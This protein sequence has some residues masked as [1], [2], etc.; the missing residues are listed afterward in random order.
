MAT[1]KAAPDLAG[2]LGVLVDAIA[3]QVIARMGG[4]PASTGK[5]PSK[6]NGESKEDSKELEKF[7][8]EARKQ[9]RDVYMREDLGAD[10]AKKI[11]EEVGAEEIGKIETVAELKK[12]TAAAKKAL[13]AK[14]PEK[15]EKASGDE[16]DFL[17]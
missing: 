6:A 2:A 13:K 3:D 9:L 11:L 12:V 5:S 17:K 4:A 1:K 8:T 15:D 14:P 7:G 16:P 10:V